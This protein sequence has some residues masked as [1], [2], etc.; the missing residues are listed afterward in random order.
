MPRSYDTYLGSFVTD[1]DLYYL[2]DAETARRVVELGWGGAGR[3]IGTRG[4]QKGWRRR[5]FEGVSGWARGSK[6]DG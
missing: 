1:T 2:E 4:E 3:G 5:C 6:V